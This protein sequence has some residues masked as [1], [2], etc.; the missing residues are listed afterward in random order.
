MDCRGLRASHVQPLTVQA[1]EAAAE[2]LRPV[3]SAARGGSAAG[4][5]AA[6]GG[7]AA[8]AYARRAIKTIRAILT[9]LLRMWLLCGALRVPC[10]L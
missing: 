4:A 8:D 7:R 3:L 10:K 1:L 2:A 6:C 5:G 9:M